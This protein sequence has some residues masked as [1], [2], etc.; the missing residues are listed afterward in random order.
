MLKYTFAFLFTLLLLPDVYGQVDFDSKVHNYIQQYKELAMQEQQRVGIPAAIKLAQG[1]HETGGGSSELAV[2]ANNHFGIKCKRGWQ[3]MTYTH[4]DDRP[5]ECFR[6]YAKDIESYIDH[7]NY[8]KSNARYAFLFDLSK[9]DYAAWAFGLRRAGYATNPKYA[10]MLIKIIEDYHLQEYTYAAMGSNIYTGD[11][12]EAD[13]HE[14]QTPTPTRQN[15]TYTKEEVL[16]TNPRY[17]PNGKTVATAAEVA[18]TTAAGNMSTEAVSTTLAAST[19]ANTLGNGDSEEPSKVKSLINKITNQEDLPEGDHSSY[20]KVVKMHGLRAVYAKKG[21][22]PLEY[23]MANNIRYQKF[24]DINEIK[25]EPLPADMYLYLERKHFKGDHPY[26]MVK[27]GETLLIIAQEEGVQKNYLMDLNHIDDGEEPIPGTTLELQNEAHQKP[28]VWQKEAGIKVKEV[29][30]AKAT[31]PQK[32]EYVAIPVAEANKKVDTGVLSTNP[33]YV[34][35]ASSEKKSVAETNPRYVANP[36][37]TEEIESKL[38]T[39]GAM[40]PELVKPAVTEPV[41]EETA[42]V[43]NPRYIPEEERQVVKEENVI[44]KKEIEKKEELPKEE[45]VAEQI[46]KEEEPKNELD[47]LK[48]QF[49]EVIYADRGATTTPAKNTVKTLATTSS[50]RYVFYTVQKGDTAFSIA[51]DH[52][53]SMKQLMDMNELDFDAIKVG[54]KLRVK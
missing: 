47:L 22:M 29:Q 25:E 2:N 33:R 53:I 6:K 43:T 23:A 12:A 1:I 50:D 16:A 41:I 21:D 19:A 11:I 26:H 18:T 10:Q 13:V 15:K 14:E 5:D 27:P 39:P 7:S 48:A 24:L 52:K 38:E 9:T 44:T 54:M 42:E 17:N 46:K 4:T 8:L 20:G 51:K 49:D 3:G 40:E 36:T 34:P 31:T 45:P 28:R 35:R 37:R 30:A 32:T